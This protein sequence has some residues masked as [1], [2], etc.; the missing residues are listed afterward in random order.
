MWPNV[1]TLSALVARRFDHLP[2]LLLL[3]WTLI[4]NFASSSA[5]I[6]NTPKS[7]WIAYRGKIYDFT[8]FASDHPGGDSLILKYAGQDMGEAM[9]DPTEHVHSRAAYEMMDEFLIGQLGGS[10]K[11]VSE[12]WVPDPNFHPEDTDTLAD[13]QRSKFIDLQKPLLAQV[14]KGGFSKE[15]YLEQVHQPRHVKVSA[16]LFGSDLLEPLTRTKWWV[17]P[18][19][20]LPITGFLGVLSLAQFNDRYVTSRSFGSFAVVVASEHFEL[21]PRVSPWTWYHSSIGYR[22]LLTHLASPLS[23]LN[24]ISPTTTTTTSTLKTLPA[25]STSTP[26]ALAGFTS[27]FALGCVVWTILEYT[28]HRFLFHLDYYLP[29]NGVAIT[30]HFLLHGIHHYLPM[31]KWVSLDRHFL[32]ISLSRV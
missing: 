17:V 24:L 23:N 4:R 6:D 10:E 30:L 25:L 19:I 26:T 7:L 12:D 29:D 32:S 15:F 22:D 14:W 2:S 21:I 18:M 5:F 3:A 16:R 20:W 8:E 13:F 9:A 31:D 28:L 1:S 27:S 11:I